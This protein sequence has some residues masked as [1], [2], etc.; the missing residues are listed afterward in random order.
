MTGLSGQDGSF[1]AE[2]LLAKG[3][4]VHGLIHAGGL[5]LASHLAGEVRTYDGDLRDGGSIDRAVAAAMPDEIYHLA[6]VTSPGRSWAAP[7]E[8]FDIVA[9]GTTRVLD[10]IDRLA[11]HARTFVAGSSEAF[12]PPM[13]EPKNETAPIA[14][15]NPYGAAKAATIS[16]ARAYRHGRGRWV[17]VGHL[18]N[19]ESHRRPQAFVTRKV[20]W[21]AAAIAAGRLSTLE[22][23]DLEASRDWGYAPEY[24]EGAWRTLQT[25]EPGEYVFATGKRHT[26][27]ELVELAFARAGVSVEDHVSVNRSLVATRHGD[28]AVGDPRKARRE[29][30]WRAETEFAEIVN[31]MVDA[32]LEL[33][34]A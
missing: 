25:D 1:L 32:D 29:L 9:T 21:H 6:G 7:A 13:T 11:P 3:Y 8:V 26:V 34:A 19:H 10:S 22:I 4:E 28:G 33:V 15:R 18:F 5:G 30:G 24:M 12:G 27:R 20:T 2:I 23:G 14:P 31:R 16:I 17:A